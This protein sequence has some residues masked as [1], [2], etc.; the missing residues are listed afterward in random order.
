MV[1]FED[2]LV[3]N[4]RTTTMQRQSSISTLQFNLTFQEIE[5]EI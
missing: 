1:D 3:Q 5:G 2:L 4:V